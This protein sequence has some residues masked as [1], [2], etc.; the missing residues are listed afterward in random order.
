[1]SSEKI[2]ITATGWTEK[3]KIFIQK[4]KPRSFEEAMKQARFI[5]SNLRRNKRGVAWVEKVGVPAH[6]SEV[7]IRK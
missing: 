5:N 7:K 6:K 4:G 1:M 2:I 3:D